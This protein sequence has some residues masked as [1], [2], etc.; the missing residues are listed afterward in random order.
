MSKFIAWL[1]AILVIMAFIVSYATSQN[2]A[3]SNGLNG[4]QSHIWP[5]YLHL[6]IATYMFIR[7]RG[8]YHSVKHPT[9]EKVISPVPLPV[10]IPVVPKKERRYGVI[11]IIRRSD[12][13]LKFGKTYNLRTRVA[14][15]RSDYRTNFDVLASWVVP[16]LDDY[17][18]LALRMTQDYHFSEGRRRELRSMSD[19]EL[20]EF[21]L[22]F[23]N[24]VQ[25]G[26]KKA[27]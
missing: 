8:H 24:K 3:E 5:F 15:H 22:S 7:V 20:S 10:T 25:N 16:F 4:W 26:F 18:R 1:T 6:P 23:T 14:L 21:I 13:I 2:L 27:S 19:S 12:G 11:Y 9:I 17:E